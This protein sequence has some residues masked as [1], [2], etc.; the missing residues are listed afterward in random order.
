[1]HEFSYINFNNF[2]KS[3]ICDL[4]VGRLY[5]SLNE[6][7]DGI[8]TRMADDLFS[9]EKAYATFNAR[10]LLLID[11]IKQLMRLEEKILFQFIKTE[12]TPSTPIPR[13]QII[14]QKQH[15]ILQLLLETRISFHQL[16]TNLNISIEKR[17]IEN[18]L[19]KLESLIKEWFLLVNQKVL[20]S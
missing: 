16:I 18:D 7:M 15:H 4:I 1:M 17:V 20:H 19:F 10:Y 5:K 13:D 14:T 8:Y 2:S 12:A 11:A 9:K 3:Q 6:K